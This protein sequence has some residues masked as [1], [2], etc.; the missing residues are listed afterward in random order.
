MASGALAQVFHP[1]MLA[2]SISAISAYHLVIIVEV[3]TI[4]FLCILLVGRVL[5]LTRKAPPGLRVLPGPKG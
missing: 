3:V 1:A 5:S 2:S 4:V